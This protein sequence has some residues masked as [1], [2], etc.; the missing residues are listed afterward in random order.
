MQPMSR[1]LW[2]VEDVVAEEWVQS[3]RDSYRPSQVADGLWIVPNWCGDPGQRRS[4]VT[5][6]CRLQTFAFIVKR[7]KQVQA[8]AELRV[9]QPAAVICAR[10]SAMSCISTCSGAAVS[11][12]Q[13]KSLL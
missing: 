12:R 7:L 1:A 2:Q 5:A 11:A 3:I 9:H 10:R 13:V 4:S 6:G 8:A